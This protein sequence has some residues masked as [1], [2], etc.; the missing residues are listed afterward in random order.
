MRLPYTVCVLLEN[1]LRRAGSDHVSEDDVRALAEWPNG[2]PGA[3]LA[4][5]PA[6]VI[7]QDL[8]GVPAVVDL[9]AM[10][11][12]VA[13]AGGAAAAVD[14]LVPVDLV[15][16]HSVQV[17]AFGSDGAYQRNIDREFERNGERYALLRWAQ[18]AFKNFRVVPPGMGIVHQVNLEYLGRVVQ[19]R[20]G[21]AMPDTLVGT[22][23]HT[24]MINA[25]GVLGWGVGGIEAEAVMLGQP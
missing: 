20:D 24:T 3:N 1:L 19:V 16:D 17:D 7:M 10:R 22:D 14:P 13:R 8:T 11:S 4:H 23:S 18:G 15:I 9:A 21:V 5:M 25:L 2:A 12:A 6:R